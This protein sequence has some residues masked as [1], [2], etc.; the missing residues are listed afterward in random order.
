MLHVLADDEE[1]I[2]PL[3]HGLELADY[4]RPCLDEGSAAAASCLLPG[5]HGGG[6]GAEVQAVVA[7]VERRRVNERHAAPRTRSLRC[8]RCSPNASGRPTR[9]C[10]SARA[11]VAGALLR[12]AKRGRLRQRRCTVTVSDTAEHRRFTDAGSSRCLRKYPSRAQAIRRLGD[13]CTSRRAGPCRCPP[14]RSAHL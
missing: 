2:L 3:V 14:S 7:H 4:V 13:P 5:L 11:G 10:S 6:D 12:A 9:S 8:R 1:M